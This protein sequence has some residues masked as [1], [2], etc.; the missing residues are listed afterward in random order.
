M[1]NHVNKAS[2]AT[3]TAI[4]IAASTV[5]QDLADVAAAA[6]DAIREARTQKAAGADVKAI[7]TKAIEAEEDGNINFC[8]FYTGMSKDDANKL[9]EFYKIKPGEWFAK[10][11]SS[12]TSVYELWF[13]LRAVRKLT[14]GGNSFDELAQAVANR[15]GSLE[16]ENESTD[17]LWWSYHTI[18]DVEARFAE[19]TV[20]EKD[21][22]FLS[23]R[24]VREG[25]TLFDKKYQ[26][27]IDNEQ[28][29]LAQRFEENKRQKTALQEAL[30][31]M[32]SENVVKELA[33]NL[34]LVPEGP[35]VCKYEVTQGLWKMVMNRN[36][37]RFKGARLPVEQVSSSD[38]KEFLAKLNALPEVMASGFKYRL[39]TK[40]EWIRACLAGG[41]D[42]HCRLEDGTQITKETFG[43]VAWFDENSGRKTHPVGQKKPNAFGLYDMHGNVWELIDTFEI[44]GS[45]YDCPSSLSLDRYAHFGDMLG[46]WTPDD[47]S[48]VG[49]RLVADKVER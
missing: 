40:E 43:D 15:I 6:M 9:A 8:G 29:E 5:A 13:S 44:Y 47:R 7:F 28:A 27:Q 11:L 22:L 36:P 37:S 21:T 38:I 33:G 49:F 23:H 1:Q 42:K 39:P 10:T 45:A 35:F 3:F 25:L 14:K 2:I 12:S 4:L 20:A 41:A 48:S 24:G 46:T 31:A 26:K 32:E 34:V 17:G 30:I 16:K 19:K 18:D